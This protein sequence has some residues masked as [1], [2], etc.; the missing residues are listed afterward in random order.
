MRSIV[1]NCVF[2]C[3]AFAAASASFANDVQLAISEELIDVRFV[4]E[5]EQGFSGALAYMHSG[6]HN[7][8]TD[9]L[10]YT[11]ATQGKVDLID[12]LLGARLFWLDSED[13]HVYGV[14]LGGGVKANIIDKLSASG[15]AYYAPDVTTGGDSENILDLSTQLN[16][17]LIENGTVFVGYRFYEIDT[18]NRFRNDEIYDAPYIG[19]KFSF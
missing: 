9:A 11:F 7:T 4:A 18:D 16:Y 8:D 3:L 10:S 14:A 6:H 12:V 13:E 19:V 1:N 17:Q 5:Y 15:E 2:G